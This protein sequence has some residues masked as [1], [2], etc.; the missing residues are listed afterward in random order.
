MEAVNIDLP[1]DELVS[2][3]EAAVQQL[4]QLEPRGIRL[5]PEGAPPEAA[6]TVPA[7]AFELLMRILAHMANGDAVTVLPVHAELTTQ[8]AADLLNVSR[9]HLVKLLDDGHIAHHK[10]GTHRRVKLVDL[11]EYKKADRQR[12]KEAL[13]ELTREGQD[14]DLGY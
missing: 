3:A 7:K 4:R 2:E 14:L 8:Q 13:D 12:R 6:V 5:M 11:L 1:T 10:V 9:P